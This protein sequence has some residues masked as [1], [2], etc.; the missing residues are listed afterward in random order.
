MYNPKDKQRT[1]LPE[2]D[3]RLHLRTKM[4]MLNQKITVKTLNGNRFR[5]TL[6]ELILKDPETI[7]RYVFRYKEHQLVRLKLTSDGRQ[8]LFKQLDKI[9]SKL[10]SELYYAKL[11]RIA[12]QNVKAK[13]KELEK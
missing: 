4:V 5:D 12:I 9:K 1:E 8:L 10:P 6:K 2:E 3:R 11:K 7:F 13:L